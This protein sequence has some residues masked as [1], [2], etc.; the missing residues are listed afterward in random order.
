MIQ[1]QIVSWTLLQMMP[2]DVNTLRDLGIDLVY[3]K[4]VDANKDHPR[5][6][7][8]FKDASIYV[9][10]D[11]DIDGHLIDPRDPSWTID[12]YSTFTPVNLYIQGWPSQFT[13][14]KRLSTVSHISFYANVV[15]LS[16]PSSSF[17]N[18]K[19]NI[20]FSS[21]LPLPRSVGHPAKSFSTFHDNRTALPADIATTYY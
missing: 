2:R 6:M 15:C 14:R 1:S 8:L 18:L 12:Q 17:T 11:L 20:Q 5:C 7:F 19:L 21:C 13:I 16:C 10:A 3:I 4:Y 9:L